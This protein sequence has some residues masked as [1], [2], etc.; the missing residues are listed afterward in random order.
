MNSKEIDD[1]LFYSEVVSINL[2]D[3]RCVRYI[4]LMKDILYKEKINQVE[5]KC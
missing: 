4:E 2:T 1:L 3:E 5:N